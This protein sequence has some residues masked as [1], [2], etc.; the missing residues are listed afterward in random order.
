MTIDG[1]LTFT[2]AFRAENAEKI[3]AYFTGFGNK[4]DIVLVPDI[5]GQLPITRRFK[6]SLSSSTQHHHLLPRYHI[7]LCFSYM[8]T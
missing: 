7:A 5:V 2:T 6:G 8:Y 1:L 3:K 4:L